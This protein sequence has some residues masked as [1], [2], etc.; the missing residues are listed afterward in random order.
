[1]CSASSLETSNMSIFNM[2]NKGYHDVLAVTGES[3]ELSR[4]AHPLP[5]LAQILRQGQGESHTHSM[6]SEVVLSTLHSAL[7]E[8]QYLIGVQ[9]FRTRAPSREGYLSTAVYTRAYLN[10]FTLTFKRWA[11]AKVGHFTHAYWKSQCWV[12]PSLSRTILT[13]PR[14]TP[15]KLGY[16]LG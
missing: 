1:M 7:L 13:K 16:G 11:A 12:I 15:S 10:F 14:L 2:L 3:N 6:A 4:L 9:S 8:L 5:I